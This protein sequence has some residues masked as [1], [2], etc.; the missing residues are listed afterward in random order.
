V[1]NPTPWYSFVQKIHRKLGGSYT[2]LIVVDRS[3][4]ERQ[5]Y[6]TF[7]SVGAVPVPETGIMWPGVATTCENCFQAN[8]RYFYTDS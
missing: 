3:E 1:E 8:R 5:I 2:F 7:T 4:L 6:D